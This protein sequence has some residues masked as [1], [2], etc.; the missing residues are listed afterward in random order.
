MKKYEYH[1]IL[2]LGSK[3]AG[4]VYNCELEAWEVWEAVDKALTG[5]KVVGIENYG[6][7]HD[8]ATEEVKKG[9]VEHKYGNTKVW[10][11]KA[12]CYMNEE[13]Y[14]EL[15][16]EEL[17]KA[18][19]KEEKEPTTEE[20]EDRYFYLMMIDRPNEEEKELIRRISAEL[21]KTEAV[22]Q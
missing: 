8:V 12:V 14:R 5:Y 1:E 11:K 15:R 17:G 6:E 13:L 7:A 2:R 20:L 22:A 21:N 19:P 16:L 18:E 3:Q 10:S 4:I 9:I